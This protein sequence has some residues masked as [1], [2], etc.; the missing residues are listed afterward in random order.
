MDDEIPTPSSE[1]TDSLSDLKPRPLNFSR[2]RNFSRPKPVSVDSKERLHHD[3][4]GTAQSTR[5]ITAFH[6]NNTSRENLPSEP[7]FSI[8]S[9]N[10]DHSPISEHSSAASEFAWD[11]ALGE[12]RSRRRPNEYDSNQRYSQGSSL[13]LSHSGGSSATAVASNGS[14]APILASELTSSSSA[15][16]PAAPP[17]A[18]ILANK[19]P[20]IL[21]STPLVQKQTYHHQPQQPQ[22]QP[23]PRPPTTHRTSIASTASRAS[24]T[25]GATRGDWE[26]SASH[27]TVSVAGDNDSDSKLR[28]EGNSSSSSSTM[29]WSS[30]EY[31]VS[32]LSPSEIRKLRK[33]GINP[34]LYAEMK[35]ARKGKGKWVGP[36]VGNT[37]IG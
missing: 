31:D 34:A 28:E 33:K 2:P 19:L 21:K 4:S 15:A 17:P 26:D 13:A 3:R 30:S 18:P 22:Q 35:A 25:A 32:G 6:N 1:G 11:G 8:D 16:P 24:T 9:N 27:H 37:F 14:D 5:S 7:R 12:L 20:R 36:L 10:T 29:P 23:Q